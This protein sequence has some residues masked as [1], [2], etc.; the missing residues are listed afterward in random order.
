MAVAEQEALR[1]KC[2]AEAAEWAATNPPPKRKREVTIT[3][4]M[5]VADA[6]ELAKRKGMR[7]ESLLRGVAFKVSD[8]PLARRNMPLAP[9]PLAAVLLWIGQSSP[10]WRFDSTK[11]D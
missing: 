9:P 2:A 1:E 6:R 3:I 8:V 11:P 10:L 4:T 7:L 5:P